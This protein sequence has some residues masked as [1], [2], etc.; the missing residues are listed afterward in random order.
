MKLTYLLEKLEYEVKPKIATSVKQQKAIYEA[1]YN[2]FN[3]LQTEEDVD[4]K[5]NKPSNILKEPEFDDTSKMRSI[6]RKF[7]DKELIKNIEEENSMDG[8]AKVF[9]FI[10]R[11]LLR[12]VVLFIEFLDFSTILNN[13]G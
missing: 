13:Y 5:V 2:A 11:I 1:L 4:F 8:V 12:A 9:N 7:E 10:P 3:E 6:L